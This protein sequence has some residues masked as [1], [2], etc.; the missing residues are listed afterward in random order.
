MRELKEAT[1][2]S[3][4]GEYMVIDCDVQELNRLGGEAGELVGTTTNQG[5]GLLAEAR[6]VTRLFIE[7]QVR[8]RVD[9]SLDCNAALS[10]RFRH[11]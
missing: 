10:V 11:H 4:D 3:K 6:Q 1:R 8:W 2:P 9:L 7:G 5:C